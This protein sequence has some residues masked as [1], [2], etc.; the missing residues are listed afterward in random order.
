V[1]RSATPHIFC[2]RPN[3]YMWQW[4]ATFIET[5]LPR[6]QEMGR[7]DRRFADQVRVDL[8]NAE[9]NPNALMITPLVLEVVAEKIS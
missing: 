4:P 5:Y 6:L 7:I 8:T 2:I 9:K 1:I 3:D